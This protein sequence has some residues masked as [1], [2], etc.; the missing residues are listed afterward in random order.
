MLGYV[1]SV[2]LI[3]YSA[4]SVEDLLSVSNET[5]TS[6]SSSANHSDLVRFFSDDASFEEDMDFV[7]SSENYYA[8]DIILETPNFVYQRVLTE[9]ELVDPLSV[10][11]PLWIKYPN[12]ETPW[13]VIKDY[14]FLSMLSEWDIAPQPVSLFN[15]YEETSM[16]MEGPS[17]DGFLNC[18]PKRSVQES[19]QL[20]IKMIGILQV[21]NSVGIVHGAVKVENFL[22][23]EENGLKIANFENARI[24]G[25]Q[26]THGWP[27]SPWRSV[28]DRRSYR[29]DLF[30]A[31]LSVAALMNGEKYI[32]I[33]E[34]KMRDAAGWR[35][36][37]IWQS[38]ESI[39]WIDELPH[40]L[41]SERIGNSTRT[42][43]TEAFM[44]IQ[45]TIYRVGRSDE[46]Q[47]VYTKIIAKLQYISDL[48]E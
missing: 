34:E 35:S 3:G 28:E 31:A 15:E 21:L 48:L 39:F 8:G 17:E 10:R 11:Y 33:V 13:T 7:A 23:A 16:T 29:D 40:P 27:A 14:K 20:G 25:Y 24:A 42:E 19:V 38:Q 46:M 26:R 30:G 6:N 4:G 41:D 18:E 37:S 47:P 2:V 43:I 32:E 5:S 12:P 22:H 45:R 44:S 1:L 36:L 9:E